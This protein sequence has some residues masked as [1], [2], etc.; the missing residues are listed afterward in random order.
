MMGTRLP[1]PP[2]AGSEIL[3]GHERLRNRLIDEL[4]HGPVESCAIIGQAVRILETMQVWEELAGPRDGCDLEDVETFIH[5]TA[6]HPHPLVRKVRGIANVR[7][8]DNERQSYRITNDEVCVVSTCDHR[9]R[10]GLEPN[11]GLCWVHYHR[12]RGYVRFDDRKNPLSPSTADILQERWE[13]TPSW[14]D[15]PIF[16]R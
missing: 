4:V 2:G 8:G 12:L 15:A 7:M 6:H 5:D 13:R 11:A 9:Q 3:L 10:I 14:L 16:A 1:R